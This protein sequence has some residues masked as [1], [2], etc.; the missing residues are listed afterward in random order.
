[1][2]LE[3]EIETNLLRELKIWDD[4]WYRSH[5]DSG[6]SIRFSDL[7]GDGVFRINPLY[8]IAE[9]FDVLPS[10]FIEFWDSM[11]P[12]EKLYYLTARLE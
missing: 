12:E 11:T 9:Y 10:E 7:L 8:E 3:E 5:I 2:S 1:V 4:L 6:D